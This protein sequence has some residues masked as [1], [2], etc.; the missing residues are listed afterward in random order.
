[1]ALEL[2][3]DFTPKAAPAFAKNSTLGCNSFLSLIFPTPNCYCTL[4]N[5][6]PLLAL[7]AV[8]FYEGGTL[9][10]PTSPLPLFSSS[11]G[12]LWVLEPCSQLLPS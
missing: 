2:E 7:T 11:W 5:P 3:K 6:A 12:G 1:M 8:L 9:Q 4:P 10:A